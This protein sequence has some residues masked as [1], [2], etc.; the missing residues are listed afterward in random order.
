MA[1]RTLIQPGAWLPL[2]AALIWVE[3]R[4]AEQTQSWLEQISKQPPGKAFMRDAVGLCSE[5]IRASAWVL[6][7]AAISHGSVPA[8]GVPTP[9]P[10]PRYHSNWKDPEK[11]EPLTDPAGLILQPF[12]SKD[13]QGNGLSLI[14]A[15]HPLVP[16]T[17]WR[18]VIVSQGELLEAFPSNM[19]SEERSLTRPKRDHK[20]QAVVEALRTMVDERGK[21]PACKQETLLEAVNMLLSQN[22]LQKVDLSTLKRA[23]KEFPTEPN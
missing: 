16:A 21:L 22:A 9:Q 17:P 5:K 20:R 15:T 12:D 1:G 14:A 7:R 6:L 4:D 13:L 10:L 18:G 11:T 2:E 23:L 19:I 3:T 8:R